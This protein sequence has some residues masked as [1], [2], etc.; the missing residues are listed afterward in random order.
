MAL[1]LLAQHAN[2]DAPPFLTRPHT[3]TISVFTLHA[4]NI[5][6]WNIRVAHFCFPLPALRWDM[7]GI[8]VAACCSRWLLLHARLLGRDSHCGWSTGHFPITTTQDRCAF[9]ALRDLL[10]SPMPCPVE[11][12]LHGIHRQRQPAGDLPTL[13]YCYTSRRTTRLPALH[14]TARACASPVHTAECFR[15]YAGTTRGL[16]ISRF[17]PTPFPACARMGSAVAAARHSP[18]DAP[19]TPRSHIPSQHTYLHTHCTGLGMAA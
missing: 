6:D 8:F 16:P 2:N 15:T 14:P 17:T 11:M 10:H 1:C 9:P 13:P 12:R 3:V 5:A 18:V 4:T 19:A 7:G